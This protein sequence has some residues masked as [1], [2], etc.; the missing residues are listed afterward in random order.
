[1]ESSAYIDRLKLDGRFIPEDVYGEFGNQQQHIYCFIGLGRE[2]SLKGGQMNEFLMV[3]PSGEVSRTGRY[4]GIR[5]IFW[6]R[7][8][9]FEIECEDVNELVSD[10]C[11]LAYI[12]SST[13][14][15]LKV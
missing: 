4:S 7:Y 14:L 6:G 1:M 9:L 13:S 5:Y 2:Q 12:A 3:F 8:K 10:Q 15:T 11:L